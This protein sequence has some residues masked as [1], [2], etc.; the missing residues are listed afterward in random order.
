MD[1]IC[2]VIFFI[3]LHRFFFMVAGIFGPMLLSA[4]N[5][6]VTAPGTHP[7]RLGHEISALISICAIFN[8]FL[9]TSIS[10]YAVHACGVTASAT[11]TG[12]YGTGTRYNHHN[13]IGYHVLYKTTDGKVIES[14]FEDDDFNIYPPHNSRTYPGVGAEFNVRYLKLFP[15]DFIIV[16][17][18]DSTWAAHLRCA[19]TGS[20]MSEAVRKFN[21]APDTPAFR[22]EYL[23]A[24]QAY[25][26]G[27]CYA[28]DDERQMIEQDIAKVKIEDALEPI[29]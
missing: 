21:Y 14:S 3:A 22:T 2:H 6:K 28:T 29:V 10:A 23:D 20:R 11:I 19:V 12:S 8:V 16:S 13:V 27:N 1:F 4:G 5:T 18:D 7:R 25:L 15:K 26:N 17:N 24:S 9:G